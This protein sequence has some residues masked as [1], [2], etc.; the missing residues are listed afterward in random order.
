MKI[1]CL[2]AHPNIGSLFRDDKAPE[3]MACAGCIP[4]YPGVGK[5]LEV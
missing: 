3:N 5:K 2:G 1:L 4:D